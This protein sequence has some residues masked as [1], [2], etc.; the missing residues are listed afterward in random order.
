VPHSSGVCL[1]SCSQQH[2][3]TAGDRNMAT[4]AVPEQCQPALQHRQHARYITAMWLLPQASKK[5]ALAETS[6]RWQGQ[7][8]TSGAGGKSYSR[9]TLGWLLQSQGVFGSPG[10]NSPSNLFCL[11]SSA[12]V[13]SQPMT[14]C[15]Y[16]YLDCFR[17]L[18]H[19]NEPAQPHVLCLSHSKH[20]LHAML[21]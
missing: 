4:Y 1:C 5:A 3:S 16:W 9:R 21:P 8:M 10:S 7:V 15:L 6:A 12:S 13:R 14:G 17:H 2:K 11:P 18:K 20:R 19:V